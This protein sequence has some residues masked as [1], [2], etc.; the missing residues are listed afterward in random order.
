L[1][2]V[3]IVRLKRQ[4]ARKMANGNARTIVIKILI[5]LPGII[6]A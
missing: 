5:A 1:A 3:L 6:K 2:S 4:A